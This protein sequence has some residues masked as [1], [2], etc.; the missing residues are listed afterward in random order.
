MSK[1][2]ISFNRNNPNN[3]DSAGWSAIH[4]AAAS[5]DFFAANEFIQFK[6]DVNLLTSDENQESPLSLAINGGHLGI[7]NLLLQCGAANPNLAIGSGNTPFMMAIQRPKFALEMSRSLVEAGAN[8]SVFAEKSKLEPNK[9]KMEIVCERLG[10][11]NGDLVKDLVE[12]VETVQIIKEEPI[13]SKEDLTIALDSGDNE[14]VMKFFKDARISENEK[15]TTNLFA[16]AGLSKNMPLMLDLIKE[17]Y[18][19]NQLDEENGFAPIHYAMYD[20]EGNGIM[21]MLL[22]CNGVTLDI[23]SRDGKTASEMAIENGM[24]NSLNLLMEYGAKA[25]TPASHGIPLLQKVMQSDCNMAEMFEVLIKHFANIEDYS[26]ELMNKYAV[27]TI[28][29]ASV[30]LMQAAR[31]ADSVFHMGGEF[32]A[33]QFAM[34]KLS[35]SDE[36]MTIFG[37]RLNAAIKYVESSNMINLASNELLE[38]IEFAKNLLAELDWQPNLIFESEL[39]IA[40]TVPWARLTEMDSVVVSDI[41]KEYILMRFNLDEAVSEQGNFDDGSNYSGEVFQEQGETETQI[42]GD[43]RENY[44]G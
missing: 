2:R 10:I 44:E 5:G 40:Q 41:I 13:I 36:F 37:A 15:Y 39:K 35:A 8:V 9:T 16:N 43:H 29:P 4:Y 18:D 11:K 42:S 26:E 38:Q 33:E 30:E 23:R 32:N 7:V 6:A 22:L 14:K 34:I 25:N 12:L 1:N 17:G 19:L 28:D 20:R 27:E 21:L 31:I 3:L 24:Y